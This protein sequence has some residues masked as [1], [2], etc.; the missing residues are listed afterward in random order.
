MSREHPCT[1]EFWRGRLPHW[2]VVDGV[3]FITIHIAGAIPG[4]AAARIQAIRRNSTKQQC[5]SWQRI[6]WIKIHDEMER[7]G[8]L[9]SSV[10]ALTN[11]QI[12]EFIMHSIEF[13]KIN[14]IWTV[15]EFVIRPTHI[16][17]V[18]GEISEGIQKSLESFKMRIG[19]FALRL[20]G[21]K[22]R[23]FW[24][25]EWF[26]HWIRSPEEFKGICNY[27]RQ[28]PTRARL[29]TNWQDWPYGSWSH[30]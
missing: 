30:K 18:I 27:I 17:F 6:P 24:Q 7:W 20:L 26:D 2:E 12:A 14:G 19:R 25:R 23:R 3:Y 29:V 22:T 5:S 28:N 21:S 8:E 13:R 9:K 10:G 4:A 1:I 11:P 15:H 16:H